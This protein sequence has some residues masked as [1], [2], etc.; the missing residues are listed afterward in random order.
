MINENFYV[1]R[2]TFAHKDTIRGNHHPGTA[3]TV[4]GKTTGRLVQDQEKSPQQPTTTIIYSYWKL[5]LL[6][7]VLS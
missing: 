7:K 6:I 4:P 2:E 5:L 3:N 1:E